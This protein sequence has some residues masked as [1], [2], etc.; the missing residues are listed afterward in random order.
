MQLYEKSASELHDMLRSKECSA[1][2]IT[3]S[4]FERIE[5]VEDRVEAYI[6]L[7]K[8]E[9]VQTARL[10]D[11]KLAK[12]E[13]LPLLAGIPV[14]VKDNLATKGV[15]TTSASKMLEGFLP[16]YD[17]TVVAKI[18]ESLAVIPGKLNLDEFAMGSSC[19]TSYYRKTKNPWDLTR[20]PGGSSGGSAA[21]LAA[22]EAILAFG[23]DTGGSIRQPG[24]YCH[25]IGMKPTYGS[26]SRYGLFALSSSMDQ[27]GPMGKT[28]RDTAMLLSVMSGHDPM[29]ATSSERGLGD[30][31]SGLNNSIKGLKIGLPKEYFCEGIDPEILQAAHSAAK[32]LEA[33]GAELVEVSL[34]STP[35]AMPIYNVLGN[36]E[37]ASNLA[38]FDGV[39]YGFR[40]EGA[41][42]FSDMFVK[43]RSEGMGYEVKRRV[44][45]GNLV[46]TE[47]K[48]HDFYRRAKYAQAMMGRE[49]DEAFEKCDVL[50]SPATPRVAFKVD[51]PIDEHMKKY[52]NDMFL[53]PSNIAGIPSLSIPCGITK[54]GLPI[55]MQLC[56][57]M[58]SDGLLLNVAQIYENI[59]GGFN[60]MPELK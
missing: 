4:V 58:F 51:A 10:V 40:A 25:V 15:Q 29:D 8:E 54:A 35:Y 27:V 21:A 47:G 6:T 59:Y 37:A 31:L 49:F 33:Q 48:K 46:L 45:L 56:G 12:G 52:A 2:E 19:Q 60:K 26:V 24:A 14:G 22:G 13:E 17:A 44:I 41:S 1:V 23:T 18:K 38:R 53:T 50:L 5:Q 3:N 57:P 20:V 28:V 7:T 39:R 55:G 30:L 43:T 16:P 32:E 11:E 34:P 42:G 9:A 36:M